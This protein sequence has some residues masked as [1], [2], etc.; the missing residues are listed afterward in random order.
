MLVNKY[1]GFGFCRSVIFSLAG[2]LS[3]PLVAEP[4]S[5]SRESSAKVST[6][7]EAGVGGR[8]SQID[9]S[10]GKSKAA[11]SNAK[12]EVRKISENIQDIKK[13]VVKLNK[14]LRVMEETLLFPSKTRYTVFVSYASDLFFTLESIKLKIDGKL[15]ATH[16]YSEKQR[17]AMMRGGVHKLF[18]T[19]ISEGLHEV[20]A[21]FM[22]KDVNDVVYKRA[23]ALEFEKGDGGEYLQMSIGDD[24]AR[25]EPVFKL[26]QW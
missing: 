20:T 6:V 12:T 4:T 17:E 23:T 19:N 16:L 7:P 15:V 10:G 25:Q 21:L 18:T 5:G 1:C 11:S 9:F 26:K 8:E 3:L 24:A 14:D 22:G 2:I 13:Q